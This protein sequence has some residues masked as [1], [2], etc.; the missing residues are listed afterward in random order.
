V[1]GGKYRHEDAMT[2]R[3]LFAVGSLGLFATVAW[4]GNAAQDSAWSEVS[5]GI[6]RSPGLPAGYALVDGGN[7][8]LIDAPADA[9]GLK[10]LGVQKIEGVLLTHHHW[11]ICAEAGKHLEAKIPVRAPQKSAE[12]LT[13][14]NVRKHWQE[15]IPLRNSRASYQVVP[16]GLEGIDCSLVDQ[17]KIDWRGWEIQVTATPGHS[18]DHVSFAVRKGRDGPLVL[19]A[20]DAIAAPGKL[21]APY[22]TDWNH[23]TDEGLTPA[24]ESLR[25]LAA[26]KPALVLPAHGPPIAKDAEQALKK[27]ADLVADV[28]FLKSFERYTKQRLGNAPE[29][30][31]LAKEQVGS[32]GK[33]PWSQISPHLYLTGNTYVLTSKDNAFMV[34]D[35]W[36]KQS[37]DQIEKLRTD[38]KLG[39]LEVV[40][41]SHAHFDHYDGVYHLPD[42]EK[43]QVWTLDRVAGPIAE[44][45][46]WRAPFLDA[47]PVK[48]DRRLKDGATAAW[49]EYSFRFA[50]FPGQTDFTMSVQTTVDG[51]KCMLTADNFFHQDQ[52]SGSGGWMGLNRSFPLP[53]AASAQKVLDAAPEWV[54]A[55]H[56][57]AFEFNAEDFRRRVRWG[58]ACATAADAI[59]PSGDHR[60][61][62]DPHRVHV[63]PLL[64]KARP[65]A[66]VKATLVA[67]NPL[68]GAVK[69][70]AKILGRGL[71]TAPEILLDI[72]AAD[73]VERNI[74]VRLADKAPPGRQVFVVRV[75]SGAG[76]EGTDAFL[77][78]DVEN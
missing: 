52:Y 36:G 4:L 38:K 33:V 7:A 74:V 67:S 49:R 76:V 75:A 11:P 28:A 12:W 1:G 23:W 21:W 73:T 29:Y 10:A 27:T 41:F 48:F 71:L 72:G 8:L 3:C 39:P 63:R 50:H 44:P 18:R 69:L 16:L 53:Y 26:L 43:F 59:S 42:R 51:K 37:A 31:F 66:E 61:D 2:K 24:A 56:G 54:L 64:Q 13:P 78:I 77:V 20:G 60:C 6:L 22:T 19:F 17:Q 57:G 25:K 9:D 62:W 35:P 14:D 32:S 15:S 30:R 65:G 5:P 45:F 58:Q 68:K 47:R 70:E 40:M 34:I 55:E 46:E